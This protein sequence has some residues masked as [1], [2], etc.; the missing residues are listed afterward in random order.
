MSLIVRWL[1]MPVIQCDHKKINELIDELESSDLKKIDWYSISKFLRIYKTW[2]INVDKDKGVCIRVV[3]SFNDIH[4]YC[5][6]KNQAQRDN[7][8][9]PSGWQAYKYVESIFE[10]VY[11]SRKSLFQAFSAKKYENEYRSIKLCVPKPINWILNQASGIKLDHVWKADVS[12]AYPYEGTKK[13]PTLEGCQKL[14]GIR[15]PTKDFPFAFYIKSHHIAIYNEL[16]THNWKNMKKFYTMYENQ[17]KD[18]CED[19]ETILCKESPYSMKPVF[20]IIYQKKMKGSKIAK[21]GMNAFIGMCHR[22]ANPKLSH[23]AACI[24]ARCC[25]RM[26]NTTLQL[27][28]ESSKNIVIFIGTDSIVWRGEKSSCA[29]DDKYLGSFTYEYH[30]TQFFA[31]GPKAYQILSDNGEVITKYAGMANG[32]DKSSLGFGKIPELASEN[33]KLVICDDGRIEEIYG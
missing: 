7:E 6:N 14:K 18:N 13:L 16:D 15:K 22:N 10:E 32:K 30:D 20:D 27:E 5:F 25:D 21:L 12:S 4:Q 17:F 24:L 9:K 31:R 11:G 23:V 2:C 26:L 1:D 8:E 3:K 33:K 29:T 28:R 19:E